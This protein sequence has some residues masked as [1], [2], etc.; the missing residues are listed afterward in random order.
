MLRWPHGAL[1]RT[2]PSPASPDPPHLSRPSHDTLPPRPHPRPPR[3]RCSGLGLRFFHFRPQR[4]DLGR[5]HLVDPRLGLPGRAVR[6]HARRR[7]GRNR[8]DLAR[9]RDHD[10]PGAGH[11]LRQRHDEPPS[12]R[13]ARPDADPLHAH[14][15]NARCTGGRRVDHDPYGRPAQDLRDHAPRAD[16]RQGQGAR[17]RPLPLHQPARPPDDGFRHRPADR[18][19]R[20]AQDQRRGHGLLRRHRQPP[21]ARTKQAS[22]PASDSVRPH[23]P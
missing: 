5:G 17:R 16:D 11:R 20:H 14:E 18:P 3:A 2:L 8:P 9:R 12:A 13:R 4:P 7:R 1:D 15:R 22:L 6:R 19:P 10:D 21:P 23:H